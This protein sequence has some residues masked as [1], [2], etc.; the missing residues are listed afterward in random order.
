MTPP[1]VA[2][3][4][5]LRNRQLGGH[6]FRRQHPVGPWIVDFFCAELGVAVE[7]DGE[8]HAMGDPGYDARRDADLS[9][10]GVRVVRLA[11]NDVLQEIDGVLVRIRA[12]LGG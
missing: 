9:M 1:E 8:S 6:R 4:K 3:W 7:V 5:A 11:T 10:R 12:E 2:L